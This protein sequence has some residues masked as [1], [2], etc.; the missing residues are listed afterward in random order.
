MS[1][2]VELPEED[3]LYLHNLELTRLSFERE[4]HERLEI[5]EPCEFKIIDNETAEYTTIDGNVLATVQWDLL[6][7]YHPVTMGEC[8]VI[9]WNWAWGLIPPASNTRPDINRKLIQCSDIPKQFTETAAFCF[10]DEVL[11]SY[12]LARVANLLKYRYVHIMDS[13]NGAFTAFGISKV[14]WSDYDPEAH[15]AQ[16]YYAVQAFAQT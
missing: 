3:L 1:E 11:V 16:L 9:Q 12:I 7:Q 6:A 8:S 14:A 15:K 4:L 2:S 10:S 13:G 5:E